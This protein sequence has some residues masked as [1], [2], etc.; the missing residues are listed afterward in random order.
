MAEV[1]AE[2]PGHKTSATWI[3]YAVVALIALAIIIALLR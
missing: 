3:L 1:Y 2:K